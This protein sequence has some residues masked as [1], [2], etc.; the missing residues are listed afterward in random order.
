MKYIRHNNNN[1]N[2]NN[3]NNKNSKNNVDRLEYHIM[4]NL[5]RE[6]MVIK[7]LKKSVH[8]L[9][10]VRDKTNIK[11]KHLNTEEITM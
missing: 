1:N 2:N 11:R 10:F 3:D 8:Q 4:S 7:V 6:S 9:N 5:F